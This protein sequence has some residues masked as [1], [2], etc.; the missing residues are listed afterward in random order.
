MKSPRSKIH[1][2]PSTT[3]HAS[4]LPGLRRAA[5]RLDAHLPGGGLEDGASP[6]LS[7]APPMENG[8]GVPIEIELKNIG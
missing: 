4:C 2:D 3:G 5:G 7:G 8:Q 1:Q 6:R